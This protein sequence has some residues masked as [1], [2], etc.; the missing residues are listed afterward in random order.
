LTLRPGPADQ[1]VASLSG[2]EPVGCSNAL[3]LRG[4][5]G[6]LQVIGFRLMSRRSDECVNLAPRCIN[7]RANTVRS[8]IATLILLNALGVLLLLAVAW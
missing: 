1:P 4:V 8:G 2:A 7:H 3:S 5:R 6:V